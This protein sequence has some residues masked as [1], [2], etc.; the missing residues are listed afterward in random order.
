MCSYMVS[1]SLTLSFFLS[2]SLSF[3][4]STDL[5]I[6]S[7]EVKQDGYEV[8]HNGKCITVF[9]AP[10]YWWDNDVI[11]MSWTCH[12]II[13]WPHPLTFSD[14]MGNKG[15]YITFSRDLQPEFIT[16]EAV[17]RHDYISLLN[18]CVNQFSLSIAALSQ[19]QTDAV[20]QSLIWSVVIATT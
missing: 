17:V 9:S 10:N 19:C 11:M 1:F 3:S 4:L 15:A 14:Q 5:L 2:L 18:E 13:I 7:H 6:R 8:A 20:C 12:V 16:Y